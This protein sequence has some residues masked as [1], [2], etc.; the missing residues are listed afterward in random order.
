MHIS[1]QLPGGWHP[2]PVPVLL[3]S[4]HVLLL[5]PAAAGIS[6]HTRRPQ[7]SQSNTQHRNHTMLINGCPSRRSCGMGAR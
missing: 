7:T 5:S 3:Y 4:A 6:M 1:S 2:S